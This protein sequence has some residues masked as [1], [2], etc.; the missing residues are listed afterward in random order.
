MPSLFVLPSQVPLGSA[1]QLLA[2][3]TLTFT[4]AGTNT[5]QNVYTD[6]A[7][8]VPAA[9]PLST[10]ANGV[11]APTYLDPSLPNYRIVLKTAAGVTLKT[12]DDV[13]SNQNTS[14]QFRLKA[15]APSLTFQETDASA[16]NKIWRI[17][18]QTEKLLIELLND[19]ESIAASIAEL[20]RTGLTPGSLNFLGQYLRV[21]G[22]LVATQ[23]SG[24]FTATLTGM[25]TTVTGTISW[26]RTGSKTTF[27]APSQIAGTSNSTTMSMTGFGAFLPGLNSIGFQP[28]IVRDNGAS[29]IGTAI[30]TTSAMVFGVGLAGGNFTASG[31]KGIPA[32][33]QI[34]IDSD[35][36][37]IA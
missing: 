6:I 16:N 1:G 25:T 29:T 35:A 2:G 34:I 8:T 11:F 7:L 22:I 19:D 26:R 18:A 30:L 28:T 9:N 21:N 4:Q 14:Q 12:W 24:S 17:R 36:A 32:G 33:W 5:A 3:A 31:S 27:T 13:P 23:E 10:D 37:G 20:T 15:A